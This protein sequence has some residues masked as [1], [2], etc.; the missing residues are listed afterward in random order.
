[1]KPGE[2]ARMGSG[3]ALSGLQSDDGLPRESQHREDDGETSADDEAMRPG[4]LA[5]CC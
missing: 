4:W 5:L 3:L 2:D 1:M